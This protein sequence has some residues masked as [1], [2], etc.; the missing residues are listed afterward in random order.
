MRPHKQRAWNKDIKIMILPEEMMSEDNVYMY[1]NQDDDYTWMR[2]TERRD[3]NTQEMFEH[4]LVH[5]LVI[6]SDG[7]P[8]IDVVDIVRY[9][10]G[11]FKIGD[12]SLCNIHTEM[13]CKVLG[14]RHE[15]RL[16]EDCKVVEVFEEYLICPDCHQALWKRNQDELPRM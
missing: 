6:S 12:Y 7:F 13:H 9:E 3:C 15:G 2:T 14:N 8:E 10:N 4:D 1:L 11:S 16:C 5:L